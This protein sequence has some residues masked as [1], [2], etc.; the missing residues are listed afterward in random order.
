MDTRRASLG[1]VLPLLSAM[2]LIS[3]CGCSDPEARETFGE[4]TEWSVLQSIE[5]EKRAVPISEPLLLVVNGYEVLGVRSSRGE[6]VWVLLK[7]AAPP[8]YKQMPQ[9]NYEVPKRLLA[10]LRREHR[11]SY[12]VEQVLESRVSVQ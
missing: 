4:K 2:W 10:R 8:F 9:G 7:P 12:T 1:K 3:L 11:L 5:F 6:N